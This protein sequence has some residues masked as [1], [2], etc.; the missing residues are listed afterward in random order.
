M[1]RAQGFLPSQLRAAWEIVQRDHSG[2]EPEQVTRL[3][4]REREF[5]ESGQNVVPLVNNIV[6]ASVYTDHVGRRYSFADPADYDYDPD[7][8]QVPDIRVS[9][10]L[11]F[12]SPVQSALDD[13]RTPLPERDDSLE[14]KV[15]WDNRAPFMTV[16]V[17]DRLTGSSSG[18]IAS[19]LIEV[20]GWLNVPTPSG[21]TAQAKL[22]M[23]IMSVRQTS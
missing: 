12:A 17:M 10:R 22:E 4:G 6:A 8:V 20:D 14:L 15:K 2:L 7:P 3:F 18:R 21:F 11:F 1:L 9:E 23:A 16:L 5:L 19:G 13:E